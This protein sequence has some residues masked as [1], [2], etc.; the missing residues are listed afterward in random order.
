MWASNISRE[1]LAA[2]VRTLC[3]AKPPEGV[4]LLGICA[5]DAKTAVAAL[6]AWVGALRLPRG[7]L[8]NADVDG[9]PLDLGNF[10]PAFVKYNSATG[11]AHLHQLRKGAFRGVLF[12]PE[13]R[14]GTLRQYGSLPLD[15]FDDAPR[16]DSGS[17]EASAQRNFARRSAAGYDL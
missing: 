1:P 16:E 7:L 13:F 8:Y 11:A 2:A 17:R 5:D 4:V 6:K 9:V 3:S 15:L 12:N 14:D 10:G